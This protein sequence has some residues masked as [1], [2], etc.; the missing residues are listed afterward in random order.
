LYIFEKVI[1][2]YYIK[3]RKVDVHFT[4]FKIHLIKKIYS[5]TTTKK[6]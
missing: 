6:L 1:L 2:L 3:L 4:N 5:V